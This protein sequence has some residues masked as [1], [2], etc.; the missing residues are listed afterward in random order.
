LEP[1]TL[2]PAWQ[3]WEP[4]LTAEAYRYVCF[5]GLNRYYVAEE[6]SDLAER[7]LAF[8]EEQDFTLFGNYG[9][10]LDDAEHPDADL[11]RRLAR[12]VMTRLPLLERGLL[13]DLLTADIAA[14]DLDRPATKADAEAAWTGV[15]GRAPSAAEIALAPAPNGSVRELYARIVDGD[16]FRA[17]CGRISASSAW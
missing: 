4:L 17:A 3:G 12:T 15:F 9:R 10:P 16:A 8:K 11:A 1:F 5:D 14:S 6:V 2:A 7:L 13:L